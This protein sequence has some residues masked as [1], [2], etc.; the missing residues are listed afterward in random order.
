M[1]G[2]TAS[3]VTGRERSDRVLDAIAVV[4]DGS[5]GSL[6]LEKGVRNACLGDLLL[7]RTARPS[8]NASKSETDGYL[9]ILSENSWSARKVPEQLVRKG[10]AAQLGK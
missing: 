1:S 9:T 6:S 10:A 4:D 8:G 3:A 7:V 2:V 5:Q